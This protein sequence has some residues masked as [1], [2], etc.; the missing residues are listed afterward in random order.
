MNIDNLPN[1]GAISIGAIFIFIYSWSRFN[2]WT[3]KEEYEYEDPPRHY[4]TWSR[5]ISYS[6]FYTITIE[7]FYIIIVIFPKGVVY[8]DDALGTGTLDKIVKIE[9][10][11]EYSF[12]WAVLILTGLM[13][14]LKWIRGPE[15]Y[16]RHKL[17][18]M[19][20]I[21]FEAQSIINQFLIHPSLFQPD[22]KSIENALKQMGNG[23]NYSI[24]DFTQPDNSIRH[25][26]CK[27]TYL[28][29]KLAEW[30]TSRD[31]ERFMCHC[32][33]EEN[34]FEKTYNKLGS[35][36]NK[37][38]DRIEEL[39][40]NKPDKYITLLESGIEKELNLLLKQMYRVI[41]CGILA[42]EKS[43]PN[44]KTRFQSL[45]L[46]PKLGTDVP[47]DWDSIITCT[48]AVFL[49]TLVT[50]MLYFFVIRNEQ[51]HSAYIPQ[52]TS[53]AVL[54]A[55]YSLVINC[56]GIVGAIFIKRQLSKRNSSDKRA[57][58]KARYLLAGLFGYVFSFVFLFLVSIIMIEEETKFVKTMWTVCL[59]PL[60]PA[61]TAMFTFHYLQTSL[62]IKESR[63]RQSLIQG[64]CMALVGIIIVCIY[65]NM[66]FTKE[67]IVFL[68]FTAVTAWLIGSSIGYAFPEGYRQRVNRLKLRTDR[69]T[70]SRSTLGESASLVL[71]DKE[72]FPCKIVDMSLGGAA[73]NVDV[74][75]P[76]GTK[77][78]LGLPKVGNLTGWI[79]RKEDKKTSLQ[80]SLDRD[81]VDKISSTYSI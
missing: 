38:H 7:L 35:N 80:L 2:T 43:G 52:S 30:Q 71:G 69:R 28:R 57:S 36:I 59:W 14:N 44:R 3:G 25:G 1:I 34:V 65:S 73:V 49:V 32:K 15:L 5:F 20:F 58:L 41:C 27:L 72:P 64:F 67:V 18:E 63:W 70:H 17:H 22:K 74:A 53:D 68:I 40:K 29:F 51:F 23:E 75:E 50:T 45:G 79:V 13:P 46:Y 12:L 24:E 66:A 11:G 26:W 39:E 81:N 16:L 56:I 55:I 37:Y 33:I 9:D 62:S 60:V 54:W 31:V 4:T 10:F 8:V 6:F 61:T 48:T 76:V 77:A 19:A 42:I 47:F 21:P 78:K